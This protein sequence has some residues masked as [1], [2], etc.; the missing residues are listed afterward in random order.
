MYQIKFRI[1][2]YKFKRFVDTNNINVVIAN[3]DK[4]LDDIRNATGIDFENNQ[5][6]IKEIKHYL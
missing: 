5:V 4:I 1:K 2:Q 6:L 3:I